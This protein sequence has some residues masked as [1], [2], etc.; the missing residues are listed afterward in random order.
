M[1]RMIF[2]FVY[3]DSCYYQ[4]RHFKT[5]CNQVDSYFFKVFVKEKKI[6]LNAEI[7]GTDPM[8]FER[9]FN[10]ISNAEILRCNSPINDDAYMYN[11][12]ELVEPK[13][14]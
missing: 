13:K 9:P 3:N 4:F 12:L 2:F 7:D 14:K 10:L 5:H 11:M 6:Y 8:I 1:E